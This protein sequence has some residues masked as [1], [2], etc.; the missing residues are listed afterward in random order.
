MSKKATALK[1]SRDMPAPLILLNGRANIAENMIN[2]ANQKNIPVVYEPETQEILSLCKNGDFVP[3]E[4]WEILVKVFS[5]I[6]GQLES[7][8]KN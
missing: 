2:I 8:S 5:F 3:F 4:T 6:G 1:Y 7:V